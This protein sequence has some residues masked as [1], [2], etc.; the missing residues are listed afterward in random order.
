MLVEG[1]LIFE[2]YFPILLSHIENIL[3]DIV[4][5]EKTFSFQERSFQKV[6][7]RSL[8]DMQF[9]AEKRKLHMV[10]DQVGALRDLDKLSIFVPVSKLTN[11]SSLNFFLSLSPFVMRI[12]IHSII[13]FDRFI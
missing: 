1:P 12:F 4:L 5:I 11:Q 3:S 6:S 2:L 9:L 8:M 10:S 13:A 7:L